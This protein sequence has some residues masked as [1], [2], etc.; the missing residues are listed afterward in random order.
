[1]GF[2][3]IFRKADQKIK[4]QSDN[5]NLEGIAQAGYTRGPPG[6]DD[7]GKELTYQPYTRGQKNHRSSRAITERVLIEPC[8][9]EQQSYEVYIF[10]AQVTNR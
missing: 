5:R 8:A 6:Q 3:P 2:T 10:D 7:F 1:M 9:V 4:S